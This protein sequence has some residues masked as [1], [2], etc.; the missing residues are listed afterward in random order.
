MIGILAGILALAA[1][2]HAQ[3]PGLDAAFQKEVA[4]LTAERRA[5]QERLRTH[6]T[7][8]ARRLSRAEA[9]ISGQ[10][11]R[12]LGLERQADAVESR[13]EEM[14]DRVSAIDA[15]REVLEAAAVST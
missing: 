10:E 15:A 4:Y 14:D 9:A 12:L 6:E 3:D 8:S 7:E 11:A 13:I 5:L 1:T 2:A